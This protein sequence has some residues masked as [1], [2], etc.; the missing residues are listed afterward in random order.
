MTDF[1][2]AILWSSLNKCR[3]N[4][5]YSGRM[6]ESL[7]DRVRFACEGVVGQEVISVYLE[8]EHL[9]NSLD[10]A[11]Q[12]STLCQNIYRQLI[13]VLNMKNQLLSIKMS[14][15]CLMDLEFFLL[16]KLTK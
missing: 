12:T 3:C 4:D 8:Y 5:T 16:L 11:L 2:N 7:K 15:S 14:K 13:Y 10:T 6:V 1:Y 9:P